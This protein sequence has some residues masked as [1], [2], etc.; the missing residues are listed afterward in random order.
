L[1]AINNEV[2]EIEEM[3]NDFRKY[4]TQQQKLLK[5]AEAL[6]DVFDGFQQRNEHI[7]ANLP[8]HLP[9]RQPR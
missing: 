1:Q 4:L 6:K 3:M 2:G 9:G 5:N 8:Q 7:A